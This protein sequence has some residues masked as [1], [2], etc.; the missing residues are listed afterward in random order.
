MATFLKKPLKLALVQLAS[1]MDITKLHQNRRLISFRR[2]QGRQ[3]LARPEQGP[4]SCT[5]WRTL[6][7]TPRVLQLPLRHTI[8]P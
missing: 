1:G 5:S 4:R 6:D 8:L 7:C 2:G 3:P